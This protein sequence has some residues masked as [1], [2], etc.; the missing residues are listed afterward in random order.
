[1]ISGT[2][3]ANPIFRPASVHLP[4][5]PPR[6]AFATPDGACV[7]LQSADGPLQGYHRASFGSS[8]AH[9]LDLAPDPQDDVTIITLGVTDCQLAVQLSLSRESIETRRVIITKETSDL[10]L[11]PVG[12]RHGLGD[13]RSSNDCLLRCFEDM[14]TRFP[15]VAAIE[16][17]N[18][19]EN[20]REK[21]AFI[22]VR[23][24]D[25]PAAGDEVGTAW[26]K[27][28]QVRLFPA[29]TGPA[30]M[31]SQRFKT[32]SRKP[33][34]LRNEDKPKGKPE[35]DKL[36]HTRTGGLALDHANFLENA[37]RFRWANG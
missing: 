24:G 16:R 20:L 37:S 26:G 34:K 1:M 23:Q 22:V 35:E 25:V 29:S 14:W 7:L 12:K 10:L 2:C 30:L 8:S 13:K 9:R 31:Q 11:K 21:R 19:D 4:S 36:E 5:A 18:L 32:T 3:Q 17:D 28:V 33:T 15:V 6:P 27:M